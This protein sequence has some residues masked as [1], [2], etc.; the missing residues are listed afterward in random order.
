MNEIPKGGHDSDLYAQQHSLSKAMESSGRID[1]HEHPD[2]YGAILDAMRVVAAAAPVAQPPAQDLS[3]RVR[4]VAELLRLEGDDDEAEVLDEAAAALAPQ[5]PA[6]GWQRIVEAAL[7]CYF[8]P[9]QGGY[10]H[11][12]ER[13]GRSIEDTWEELAAACEAIGAKRDER[14]AAWMSE[15][16][17]EAA[18]AALLPAPPAAAEQM[19]ERTDGMPA[20]ADERYLRRLLAARAGI[21]HVYYDDGEAQGHEHGIQ[22]DFMR[23]PVADIDAKMRALVVA[24]YEAHKS[25]APA[26]AAAP[27]AMPE[28]VMWHPVGGVALVRQDDA[29]A[30]AAAREAAERERFDAAIKQATEG[31]GLTPPGTPGSYARGYHNGS[32]DTVRTIRAAT[33]SWTAY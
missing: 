16:D 18:I 25:A 22:I 29:L 19:E 8:C 6:G 21:P 27:V 3:R 32:V 13:D 20:S 26:P 1:Q 11:D 30:Y 15:E 9:D 7:W 12:G 5:P 31:F 2:A 33:A 4:T 23:E 24:R 28:P 17:A 10:R 14:P